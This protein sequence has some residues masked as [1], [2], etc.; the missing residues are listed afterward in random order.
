MS[1]S[2]VITEPDMSKLRALSDARGM[3]STHD[4][5]HLTALGAE[6]ERADV[7]NSRDVPKDVVTMHTK[8]IVRDLHDRTVIE[9]TLVFPSSADVEAQRISVLA[10]FGTAL[11][12]YREGD[13]ILW[14]MPGGDRRLRIERVLWQP[15]AIQRRN[16]G[17]SPI[18]QPSCG[19]QLQPRSDREKSLTTDLV[20]F[21]TS[22]ARNPVQ[23]TQQ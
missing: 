18:E 2:I 9:C 17:D 12:G 21:E 15:E 11:L 22:D 3:P 8:V 19:D 4:Q 6:L 5:A 16:T 20:F 14:K 10:P 1:R 7:V 23:E 13:E